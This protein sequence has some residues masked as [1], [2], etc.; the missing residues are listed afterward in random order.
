MHGGVHSTLKL[1]TT[2]KQERTV[3]LSCV[4]K[5]GQNC[6]NFY[7]WGDIHGIYYIVKN[8]NQIWWSLCFI[9][10][11]ISNYKKWRWLIY[12]YNGYVYV[13]TLSL[14]LKLSMPY[15]NRGSKHCLH[16]VMK[17]KGVWSP[18]EIV[19]KMLACSWLIP[20]TITFD[21]RLNACIT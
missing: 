19:L 9:K 4:T 14:F 21:L 7:S 3:F 5:M 1:N 12:I 20:F 10:K 17:C 6:I 18:R 13:E 11:T 8:G 16:V 15:K 2:C